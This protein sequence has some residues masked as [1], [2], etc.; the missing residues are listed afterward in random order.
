VDPDG[1]LSLIVRSGLGTELGTVQSVGG[2]TGSF[3]VG[4]N[5]KGQ[6]ALPMRVGGTSMLALLTPRAQ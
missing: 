6:V 1:N 5:N 4:L 3:G 2:A